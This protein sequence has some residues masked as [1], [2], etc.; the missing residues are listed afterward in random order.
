[1]E[2]CKVERPTLLDAGERHQVACLL[3]EGPGREAGA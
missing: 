3:N 2:R 1:M